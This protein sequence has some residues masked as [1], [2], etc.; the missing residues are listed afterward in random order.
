MTAGRDGMRTAAAG[1]MLSARRR[2]DMPKALKGKETGIEVLL[3]S[4]SWKEPHP[5]IKESE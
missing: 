4:S 5:L 2:Y 3:A 1:R